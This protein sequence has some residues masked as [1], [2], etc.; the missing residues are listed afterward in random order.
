MCIS[1]AFTHITNTP[2]H[3]TSTMGLMKDTFCWGGTQYF[4]IHRKCT[5]GGVEVMWVV[6]RRLIV[7][8][9]VAV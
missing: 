1:S 4:F 6:E 7:G 3:F 5:S 8:V 2:E 9:A